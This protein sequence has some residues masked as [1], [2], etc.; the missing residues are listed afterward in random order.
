[1]YSIDSRNIEKNDIFIPIKGKK[2]DAHKFIPDLLS[3]GIK[4]HDVAINELASLK[5][6]SFTE[7]KIIAITGS[8]GKTTLKDILFQILSQ[9][10][11]VHKTR[12]NENN[13]IGV[14]LTLLTAPE[15]I[16]YIIIEMGMRKKGDIKYLTNIIRPDFVMITNIGH[17]HI[18][19]LKTQRN[20]ALAKSEIF[21]FPKDNNKKYVTFL[22]KYDNFYELLKKQA[23]KNNFQVLDIDE[24][25]PL[26]SNQKLAEKFAT[27]EGF[28]AKELTDIL[29]KVT[30]ISSHRNIIIS[31]GNNFI[32]DDTYNA[33]PESVE[34]AINKTKKDYPDKALVV[35]LGDMLELGKKEDFFHKKNINCIIKDNNIKL[36]FF[37]GSNYQRIEKKHNKCYYYTD[38]SLIIKKIKQL[39]LE[40]TI[41]LVKGSRATKMETI[42]EGLLNND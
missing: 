42:I 4:I 27:E 9:K 26:V 5:R 8:S 39:Q 35:I 36:A 19:Q 6:K 12:E 15:N 16:Q 20:I 17:A 24:K 23:L 32:I 2:F 11:T 31:W 18:E 33:N 13:E 14:P 41:I 28:Q 34:F 22:N 38:K 29:K 40:N 1:V 30:S 37:F 10:F 21:S 7:K 25:N 3:K